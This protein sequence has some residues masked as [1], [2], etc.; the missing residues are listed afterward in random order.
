MLRNICSSSYTMPLLN[1]PTHSKLTLVDRSLC[2]DFSVYNSI[3]NDV[4][5]DPS[6]SSSKSRLKTYL[7][8]SNYNDG[9]IYLITVH[10]CMDRSCYRHYFCI[11]FLT[12]FYLHIREYVIFIVT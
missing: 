9:I 5:C 1:M 6:L 11:F 12:L 8:G 7:F 10:M 3:P 2:F 4:G